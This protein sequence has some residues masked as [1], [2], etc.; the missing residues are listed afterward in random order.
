MHP[1]DGRVVSNFL[2]QSLA[3]ENITI[4]GDGTQTRSFCYVEDLVTGLVR[5]MNTDNVEGPVNLGNPT[6]NTILELAEMV[7]GLRPNA[8]EIIFKDLPQDD[9]KRR[10]PDITRAN[11]LLNWRP[12]VKLEHGLQA[13]FDYF[14]ELLS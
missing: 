1:K 13:T 5:L 8:P 2:V 11:E 10:K 7:R 6:E 14:L 12:R 4:Y 3:G 9:P